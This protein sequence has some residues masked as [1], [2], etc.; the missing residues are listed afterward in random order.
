[1]TDPNPRMMFV[2]AVGPW[3]DH[4]AWLP[5]YT[6]DQRLFWLCWVRRRCMQKHTYLDGGPD[7]SWQYHR[8]AV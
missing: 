5:V 1:M 7:F 4:F 6:Y 3:H 2:D 8:E